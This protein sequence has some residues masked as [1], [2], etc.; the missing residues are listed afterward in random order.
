M[1]SASYADLLGKAQPEVIR[2][3]RSHHR[4]LK[5]IASLMSQSRLTLAER[6]LLDLLAK[7]VD[8]YEETLYPTPEVPPADMLKHLM[9]ARGASQADVAR[10]TGVPRSTISE[11]LNGKRSLSVENAYRLGEYFHVEPSLFLARG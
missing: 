1:A 7:L 11:V 3:D 2:D 5:T 8:D 10:A 4:A 6:K 9:E